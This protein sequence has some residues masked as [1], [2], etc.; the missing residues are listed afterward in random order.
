[1]ISRQPVINI[2]TRAAM[3]VSISD[4][5]QLPERKPISRRG[6]PGYSCSYF[7][8]LPAVVLI[9]EE[10]RALLTDGSMG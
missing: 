5:C 10:E 6:G 8:E 9:T 2:P 4:M 7:P 3:T 1:M